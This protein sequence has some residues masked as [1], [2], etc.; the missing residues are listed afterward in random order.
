[1]FSEQ[2]KKSTFLETFETLELKPCTFLS[3]SQQME[4]LVLNKLKWDLASV[5]PHDFIEHFL[6][7][8][9][10]HQSAKQILRKH[11]Q[12]FVA[13]CATGMRLYTFALICLEVYSLLRNTCKNLA[14]VFR[15]IVSVF[16]F[17]LQPE[18]LFLL[19]WKEL[20]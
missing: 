20:P 12:T 13:L 19:G 17:N 16:L 4:L 2:K 8:L 18:S 9:P 15:H 7:K 3:S 1:M 14:G 5:T 6:T 11:A 10:I